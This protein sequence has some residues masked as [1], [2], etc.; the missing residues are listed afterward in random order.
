MYLV[1]LWRLRMERRITP[2]HKTQI[3]VR[4]GVGGILPML[5]VLILV[6]F[7]G[8]LVIYNIFQI[9]VAGD[10]RYYGLLK[11]IG[12]TPTN[13]VYFVRV[14]QAGLN[15]AVRFTVQ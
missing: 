14:R 10:I 4:L 15:E 7:T 3:W 5:P 2:S 12:V 11:T 13:R 9:S 6:A 1:K 8:Y